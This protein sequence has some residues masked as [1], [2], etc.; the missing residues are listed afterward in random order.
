MHPKSEIF[1]KNYRQY[2]AQIADLDF[3]SIKDTLGLTQDKKRLVVPFFD[4][5]YFVSKDGIAGQAGTRPGYMVCVILSKYLLLC[6]ASAND[7]PDWASLKDFKKAAAFFNLNFFESDTLKPI[8]KRF[9]GRLDALAAACETL[10]GRSRKK[11]FSYDLAVQ[12]N[13]LPRISLLLLFNDGD[14]EFPAQCSL[15][16][17]KQAEY[18][19]DPESLVMT[20]AF[21]ARKLTKY[22]E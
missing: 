8:V 21:L 3:A 17:Q 5:D 14:E 13:A 11:E 4:N 9:A 22:E 10:G 18:Y 19:L 16:F 6:P 2:C 12:F 1:E 7:D 20:S 15:L